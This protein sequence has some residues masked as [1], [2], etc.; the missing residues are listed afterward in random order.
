M[1]GTRRGRILTFSLLYVSEG[2]PL[3]LTLTTMGT[4]LRQQGVGVAE[5]GAFTAALYA[6][7]GFKWAWAPLIDLI[8]PQRFGPH[9]TWIVFS[10]TM[11]IV[12]LAVLLSFD[13]VANIGLLIFFVLVHNVFAATQDVAIDALAVRVLKPE[14]LGTANGFMFAAA[15]FGQAIGGGA[16]L[17]VSGFFGFEAAF[18][19]TLVVL[20]LLL[21]FVSARL[22]EPPDDSEPL[23][24]TAGARPA[25]SEIVRLFVERTSSFFKEVFV[26][27]FRSGRGPLLGVFLALLPKGAIALGL[28]VGITMRV[29]L[30][31][32]ESRIALLSIVTNMG[33][34]I[35]C[36]AG[37]WISDRIGHR[38][39]LGIWFALTMLPNF[40][41]ASQF[42]GSGVAGVTVGAFSVAA[43][44]AAMTN[45]LQYGTGNA[46][47][48]SLTNKT[49]AA[50]QFTGY[51][52]L[53]NLA[54]SYSSL[55][56]GAAAS[57][58]GYARTLQLDG[59]FAIVP[60]LLLP[61]LMAP[62]R[63]E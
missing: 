13:Y 50:T 62:K 34:A 56:Q 55:W 20:A 39:A 1:L 58:W 25:P 59:L 38:K 41:L 15:F 9:R 22:R 47:F 37:G 8:R 46:V 54:N 18:I 43:V 7:W 17:W 60:I 48:M 12:T 14:E 45:G 29:D 19:L 42:G 28:T 51:M 35:G 16:A 36:I 63:R 5:I 4:Y 2:I 49:V 3:G 61:F 6:P 21:V 23:F 33:G 44:L 24:D 11:M 32:T 53:S 52:A 27:F 26:G 10:Q 30:G 40:Y 57:Q 31:M